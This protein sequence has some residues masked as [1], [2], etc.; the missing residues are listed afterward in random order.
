MIPVGVLLKVKGL[1]KLWL[2]AFE[3]RRVSKIDSG[4]EGQVPIVVSQV[5]GIPFEE[6]VGVIPEVNDWLH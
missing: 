1:K 4:T 5:G 2:R 3:D 6:S